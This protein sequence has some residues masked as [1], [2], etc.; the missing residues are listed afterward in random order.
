MK[1]FTALLL[2]V[3]LAAANLSNLGIDEVE[4]HQQMSA[5]VIEIIQSL[6]SVKS[7][8]LITSKNYDFVENIAKKLDENA[9]EI[10]GTNR[11]WRG[12]SLIVLDEISFEEIDESFL[13][14][15]IK[16]Q[17]NVIVVFENDESSTSRLA[18]KK[19]LEIFWRMFV[20]NIQVLVSNNGE[21]HLLTFFPFTEGFC[22]EVQPVLWNIF[23]NSAFRWEREHFPSKAQ[24]FFKCE[25]SAAI[26]SAP[27]Y[28]ILKSESG[29]VEIDGGVDGNILETLAAK[30]NFSLK[31]FIVSEDL[32]W[33]E[34]IGDNLD[35]NELTNLTVTGAIGMV[36]KT[37]L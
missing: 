30:L 37:Y 24:N 34:I 23:E 31:F 28:M 10:N 5:A 15:I 20:L 14:S 21:I 3:G 33:G 32:R 26:F 36:G 2:L 19:I 1:Y 17:E 9:I 8:S 35:K 16:P 18:V 7:V 25:L 11:N 22:N 29:N 6:K 27:P 12:L 4:K 13:S